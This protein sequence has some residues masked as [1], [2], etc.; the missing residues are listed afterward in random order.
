[1]NEKLK[2]LRINQLEAFDL[3][4]Y[5]KQIIQHVFNKSF[6]FFDIRLVNRILPEINFIIDLIFFRNTVAVDLTLP[7]NQ[8][9]N[10]TF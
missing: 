10:V 5:C 4:Q 6:E 7:G 9:E 8:I 1:M 3:D 2:C